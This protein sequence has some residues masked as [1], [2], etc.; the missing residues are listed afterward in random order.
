MRVV[1][2]A[3]AGSGLLYS[4]FDTNSRISIFVSIPSPLRESLSWPWITLPQ[5]IPHPSFVALDPMQY[6]PSADT[7]KEVSREVGDGPKPCCRCLGRDT[8]ANAAARVGPAVVNLSVPQGFHG[9]TVGKSIG[10]GTI[11]DSDGTI[12]TCA[13]VVVGFQG[14]RSS[15]KGTVDVT[16]QDGRTFEGTV[17]NAD[18]HSDI[19]IVKIK[20]KTPLPT[21]ILALQVSFVQGIGCCVDRKSSDLGLGGMRREYLQTD[22]AINGGNSGG[23]LVNIDGEVVGVN[24]M[25]VLAADGLSFAVPIDSV[26]TIIEHFKKNGRVVRPWLGLKMLDLNDMIVAQLR[27]KD[28]MFPNVN[29]G[30]LVPMGHLLIALDSTRAMLLLKFDGRPVGSIKEIIEVMG[31]KVGKP[32]KAVVKR[33]KDSTVSL[34][35][36]PEEEKL[37]MAPTRKSRSVNKRFSNYTEASRDNN[38][39]NP[40][41]SRQRKRKLSNMLGT[42]W[43]KKELECFYEAYRKY[44]QAWEKVAGA[45]RNRSAE[46]VEALYNMNKAY[47]SL[48]DGTASVV[49]L[50]A[51]MTDHYNVLEGSDSGQESNGASPLSRKSKKG[52]RGKIRFHASKEDLLLS[53][54][55]VSTNDEYFPLLKWRHSDGCAVRKRTPRVP[56]TYSFRKDDNDNHDSPN[57]SRRNS[58]LDDDVEHV[59][60][61][62]L[63]EASLSEASPQVSPS[64]FKQDHMKP[65]PFQSLETK[66]SQPETQP[67]KSWAKLLGSAIKK[68]GLEVSLGSKGIE[69]GDYTRYI[70]ALTEKGKR[71]YSKKEKV[72]NIRIN[73]FDNGW[74]A[75]SGTENGLNGDVKDKDIEVANPKIEHSSS[76][77]KRKRS[78]KL[79]FGD[80]SPAF[81]ALQTLAD[82]SLMMPAE[83]VESESFVQLKEEKPTFDLANGSSIN[84]TMSDRGGKTKLF[85]YREK[86]RPG[87]S[88]RETPTSKKSKL[89]KDVAVNANVNSEGEQQSLPGNKPLKIHKSSLLKDLAEE[90]EIFVV[91][92]KRTGQK[93][94][95][96]KQWESIR[97]A[98]C[99]S[100][101]SD[102]KRV[103]NDSAVSTTGFPATSHTNLSIK[104]RRRCK[105]LPGSIQ[106]KKGIKSPGETSIDQPNKYSTLQDK[107][108]CCLSSS[109]VRKWCT[110]EWFYSAIDY[111]WFANS[112]FVEYLNH[113]GLGDIPRLNRVEWGVIRSSLGKPRRFSKHFLLEEKEKLKQYRES[114]RRHYAELRAGIRDGLPTDLARPLSVGQ[115]VIALHPKSREVHD[116]SVLTVDHDK[117]RIQFDRPELGVEFVMDIDCMPLNPWENVPEALRRQSIGVDKFSL[118]PRESKARQ[119]NN[120][121]TVVF[122]PSEH[123]ENAGS[124]IHTSMKQAR[125]DLIYAISK[126]KAEPVCMVNAP[127]AA[128]N[129]PCTMAHMQ[130]READTRALTKLTHV[131]NKK[132]QPRSSIRGGSLLSGM[133]MK[134]PTINSVVLLVIMSTLP[135]ATTTAATTTVARNTITQSMSTTSSTARTRDTTTTTSTTTEGVGATVSYALLN[136]RQSNTFPWDSLP[137][138]LKPSATSSGFNAPPSS[139]NDKESGYNVFKIIKDSRFKAHKMVDAAV[140]AISSIKER[141]DAFERIGEA[142]DFLDVQKFTPDC[143]SSVM[144]SAE[145]ANGGAIQNP[146]SSTSATLQKDVYRTTLSAGRCGADTRFCCY[147][148][149]SV[150]PSEPSHLQRDTNVHGKD[151]NPAI[152]TCTNVH[153]LTLI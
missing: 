114:V 36:I 123:L 74:E 2:L 85:G 90:E 41:K 68:D 57:K 27:E 40:K 100:S 88:G 143:G 59:A 56:V 96:S 48:P 98:E 53:P 9:L 11:I 152:S 133:T 65:S 118:N 131:P 64:P 120:G 142:L 18:L 144:K 126:A 45:V 79:L 12:L 15:S 138:C 37:V 134:I 75:F 33:A 119:L 3:T 130:A 47:L 117:C 61:L 10:S 83:T 104:Q 129:H 103:G 112:E 148:L 140:Q 110:F 135:W 109:M 29:K 26:S 80:E 81:D 111:P 92:G 55:V 22:C 14:L 121:N 38:D 34:I 63:T 42:Q 89:V 91:K 122:A 73:Q 108:S 6:V 24:I 35:V 49:G 106:I 30:V 62:A 116:G 50:I 151:Q 43:S 72:E 23:P 60:A 107:L 77:G 19:A 113:V 127:R 149:A 76:L 97:P 125:S 146:L 1:A 124:D 147:K 21:Q 69:N 95:P 16:L 94:S 46:M 78:K 132:T 66:H 13:H 52:G 5:M 20:S 39:G 139:T 17:L 86:V 87:F 150:L 32:L 101:G 115:R 71:V 102:K 25:K 145:Q 7:S 54:P 82:L 153:N 28:A 8:I 93:K 136:S 4:N 31:D 141:E 70:S 44:G 105:M 58:Q 128:C 137:S 51:M 84:E 99:S 67:E